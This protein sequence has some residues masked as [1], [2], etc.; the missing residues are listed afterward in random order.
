MRADFPVEFG[1]IPN[2]I[3]YAELFNRLSSAVNMLDKVR[4]D[5]PLQFKA[6]TYTYYDEA[7]ITLTELTGECT[8]GGT[9]AAYKDSVG[10][11]I[12]STLQST[13]AWDVWP[14]STISAGKG[15]GL[16]GCPYKVYGARTDTE[17]RVE[18][19]P[20]FI[21]AVPVPLREL[22]DN[23]NTGFLANRTIE[24]NGSFNRASVSYADADRCP[25]AGGGGP[26]WATET[27]Q[28]RWTSNPTEVFDCIFVSSGLL[29]AENPPSSDLNIGRTGSMVEG[30]FCRNSGGSS[31]ALTLIASQNAWI[32]FQLVDGA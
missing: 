22:I 21:D 23:G 16:T 3:M 7:E 4:L 15:F 10:P 1:P 25:A 8:T 30:D 12:A 19:D 31:V 5:I 17:Y 14:I 6:R 11:L 26:H 29:V 20:D 27:E 2:T 28:Y 18:I 9:C 13:S 24:R 32:A